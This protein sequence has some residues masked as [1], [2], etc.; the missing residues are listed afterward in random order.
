MSESRQ[1]P[2]GCLCG[3]I[4]YRLTGVPHSVAYCHCRMCQK[5]S[6]APVVNWATF[7]AEALTVVRGKLRE[8]TS[9]PGVRRGFCERCGS[10]LT[11]RY[12]SAGK[13]WIDVTVGS[14]DDTA[15]LVPQYHI[16]ADSRAAWLQIDDD[17][18]RH[19]QNGPDLTPE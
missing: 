7:P 6:G 2:G 14:F 16:W 19:A 3:A 15:D 13:A 4:R 17:L 9:S 8:F 18:P 10:P 1:W 11:F 5:A 12:R